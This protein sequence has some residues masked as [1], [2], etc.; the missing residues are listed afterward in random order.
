VKYLLL[1][2]PC[3]LAVWAPLY[4]IDNPALFGIPFFY[5]FQMLLVLVSSACIYAADHWART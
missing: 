4:N 3:V 2:I 1:L 5:W